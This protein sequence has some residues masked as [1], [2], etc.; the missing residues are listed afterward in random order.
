MI[1]T[2]NYYYCIHSPFDI[3]KYLDHLKLFGFITVKCYIPRSDGLL[4]Q[5]LT[6]LQP[7]SLIFCKSLMVAFCIQPQGS[8]K[9]T[10]NENRELSSNVVSILRDEETILYVFLWTEKFKESSKNRRNI[11]EYRHTRITLPRDTK[12]SSMLILI[13]KK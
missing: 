1:I 12:T 4:E 7:L 5:T 2:I 11:T 3:Q 9:L 8:E 6:G 10:I 13:T